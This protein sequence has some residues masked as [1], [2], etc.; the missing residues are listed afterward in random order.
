MKSSRLCVWLK[1]L[2]HGWGPNCPAGMIM[3]PTGY[4]TCP[5]GGG[6]TAEG[7]RVRMTNVVGKRDYFSDHKCAPG[8]PLPLPLRLPPLP[9]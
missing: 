9:I 7:V 8:I 2:R 3:C 6:S 1:L 4:N 5:M